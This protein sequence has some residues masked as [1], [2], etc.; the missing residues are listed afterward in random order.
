MEKMRTNP[1]SQKEI[2]EQELRAYRFLESK[3][4]YF[5]CDVNYNLPKCIGSANF[6]LKYS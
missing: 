3:Q 5:C 4:R 6:N 2:V 1:M